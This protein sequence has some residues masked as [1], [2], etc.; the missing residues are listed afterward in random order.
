MHTNSRKL[1]RYFVKRYIH[2]YVSVADIG[3]LDVNGTFKDLFKR[4]KYEGLDIVEGPNVDR[5]VKPYDFGDKLYDVVISGSTMEHVEDLHRWSSEVVRICVPGGLI[6]IIAPSSWPE[7]KYP[8]DC[9]RILPDG[10][11]FL[12]SDLEILE[13]RMIKTV[14]RGLSLSD[15]FLVARKPK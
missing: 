9:W 8:V 13:N 2:A 7:H 6:C 1:M 5:V 3:S 14:A 4:A 15:T 10:M 12:F 11:K